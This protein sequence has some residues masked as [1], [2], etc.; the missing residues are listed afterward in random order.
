MSESSASLEEEER[1]VDVDDD[2]AVE[3]GKTGENGASPEVVG[4]L[5]EAVSLFLGFSVG[6][7]V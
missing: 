4:V 7:S 5:E 6:R 1:E 2:E 3:E